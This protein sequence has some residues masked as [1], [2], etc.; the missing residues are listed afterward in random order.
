[1]HSFRQGYPLS[2]G[3][4]L[5]QLCA[6]CLVWWIAGNANVHD[7]KYPPTRNGVAVYNEGI[8]PTNRSSEQPTE[9]K[10]HVKPS[11][12]TVFCLPKYRF[13]YSALLHLEVTGWLI[14]LCDRD[15]W[16]ADESSS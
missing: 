13:S 2:N 14:E 5:A 7:Q 11:L 10:K 16:I 3:P 15:L 12:E 8:R 4:A 1:M 9:F 6:N